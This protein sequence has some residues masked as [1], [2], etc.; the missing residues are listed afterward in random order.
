MK[1]RLRAHAILYAASLAI[2]VSSHASC[3]EPDTAAGVSPEAQ[4]IIWEGEL[5]KVELSAAIDRETA[6]RLLGRL[7]D[8]ES[9]KP[10]QLPAKLRAQYRRDA[11]Y[12]AAKL[13]REANEERSAAEAVLPGV[14]PSAP[15]KPRK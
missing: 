9:G 3:G 11:E 15:D 1:S 13:R 6:Q 5:R 2:S 10:R 7:F 8:L 14:N 4:K 12:F